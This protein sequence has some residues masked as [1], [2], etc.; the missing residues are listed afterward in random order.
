[1]ILSIFL[2]HTVVSKCH[3]I[4]NPN[5]IRS[6]YLNPDVA[7]SEAGDLAVLSYNLHNYVAGE[8]GQEKLQKCWNTT[9]VFRLI[10][11]EWRTVH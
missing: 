9:E 7:V 10:N 2:S 3:T 6:E 8:D 4:K 5:I 11:G 1:M